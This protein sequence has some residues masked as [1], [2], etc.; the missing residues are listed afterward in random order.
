MKESGQKKF[1]LKSVYCLLYLFYFRFTA[2][3]KQRQMPNIAF[4]FPDFY[5]LLIY[6]TGGKPEREAGVHP[7]ISIVI[8]IT[9]CPSS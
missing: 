6:S 8:F 1:V 7:E 2:V 9:F 3:I 4:F 5:I